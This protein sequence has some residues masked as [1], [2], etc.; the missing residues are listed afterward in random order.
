[1]QGYLLERRRGPD[2][3]AGVP[4]VTFPNSLMGGGLR[5]QQA[6]MGLIGV[7]GDVLRALRESD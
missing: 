1:M 2:D 4:G 6:V 3:V 7:V 5:D